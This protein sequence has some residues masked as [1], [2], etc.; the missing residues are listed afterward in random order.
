VA[1]AFLVLDQGRAEIPWAACLEDSRT[2]GFNMKLYWECLAHSIRSGC[3][4]F[5]FGRSTRDSGTYR[6]KAQ[7]GA[8]PQPLRWHRWESRPGSGKQSGSSGL[9]DGFAWAWQ[10]LPFRVANALGPVISPRLPW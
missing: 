5:D 2:A 10:R 4:L 7:W 6:F 9:R 1:A 8:E 3:S